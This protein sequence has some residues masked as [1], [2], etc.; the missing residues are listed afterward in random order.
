MR[1]WSVLL[2][3]VFSWHCAAPVELDFESGYEP[4]IVVNAEFSPD[5]EWAVHLSRSIAY[6]DSIDWSKQVLNNA[7]VEIQDSDGFVESLVH[8]G[9]GIYESPRG[10]NPRAETEYTITASAPGFPTIQASS[11]APAV[12]AEFVDIREITS[13]DTTKRAF[14]VRIRIIDQPGRD[15]YSLNVDHLQPTCREEEGSIKIDPVG[16]KGTLLRFLK[17]DSDL[18]E[19]RETIPQVNDPSSPTSSNESLIS[20]VGYFSDRSLEEG[21]NV[22]EVAMSVPRYDALAPH[23]MIT[24]ATWSKELWSYTESTYLDYTFGLNIFEEAPKVI[25][26]NVSDGLGVFAGINYQYL[27]FDH[28]GR[29]WDRDDLLVDTIQPCDP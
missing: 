2:A 7:K 6:V 14:R 27:Q 9:E 12:E 17:F 4:K 28:E 24:V 13:P 11:M 1:S 18:R 25:Y 10:T 20:G 23:L 5:D 8:T 16:S 26:S 15:F 19:M 3:C 21:S 29:A 22:I